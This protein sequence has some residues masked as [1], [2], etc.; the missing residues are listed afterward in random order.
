[1]NLMPLVVQCMYCKLVLITEKRIAPKLGEWTSPS[2]GYCPT[3][4]LK[5]RREIESMQAEPLPVECGNR[6]A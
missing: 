1:M 4:A 5:V 2:H 3:C 6:A